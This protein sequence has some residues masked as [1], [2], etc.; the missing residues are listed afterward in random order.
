MSHRSGLPR[1]RAGAR[2][3]RVRR[4]PGSRRGQA[5]RV[6]HLPE[7][8]RGNLVRG[9][10]VEEVD[11]EGSTE[12]PGRALPPVA[13]ARVVL[14]RPHPEG[15]VRPCRGRPRRGSHRLRGIRLPSR[16]SAKAPGGVP[17]PEACL[18]DDLVPQPVVREGRDLLDLLARRRTLEEVEVEPH[19]EA[20][21]RLRIVEV[22]GR[23]ED[24]PSRPQ[25][26]SPARP[27]AGRPAANGSPRSLSP[28]RPE[29]AKTRRGAR[30][31]G[32][33]RA[34]AHAGHGA[35]K[36]EEREMRR[37]VERPF[38]ADFSGG[39]ARATGCRRGLGG[40][41]SISSPSPASS[42]SVF[43]PPSSGTGIGRGL[44]CF[45]QELE[46]EIEIEVHVETGVRGGRR[47]LDG[48]QGRGLGNGRPARVVVPID[49]AVR[50][51]LVDRA[52]Q[53]GG[54]G[55]QWKRAFG[56]RL[57]VERD[58]DV[59]PETELVAVGERARIFRKS[60]R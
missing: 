29:T 20:R 25:G 4:R 41:A 7:D 2:H 58:P 6:L 55:R 10:D 9:S 21:P 37:G 51:L 22:R 46:V 5:L 59:A 32:P 14:A 31:R 13:V 18:R 49:Q 28:A 17:R 47:C 15:K 43:S 16:K 19:N 23:T 3:P 24:S 60:F 33:G 44:L 42:T 27:S 35:Q 52:C 30:R 48:R 36:E 54:R 56:R 53:V 39:S 38:L 11:N 26:S 1:S 57:P 40:A 50:R 12:L 45:R 34:R 8:L